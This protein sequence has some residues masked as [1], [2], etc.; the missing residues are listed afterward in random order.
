MIGTS[1]CVPGPARGVPCA[2][3]ACRSSAQYRCRG[4]RVFVSNIVL[5]VSNASIHSYDT[6]HGGIIGLMEPLTLYEANRGRVGARKNTGNVSGRQ[7]KV[8]YEKVGHY[9]PEFNRMCQIACLT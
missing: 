9:L 5:L 4:M 8:A 1:V 2:L 3:H 7:A 6:Q